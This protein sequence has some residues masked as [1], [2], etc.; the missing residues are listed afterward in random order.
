LI[1]TVSQIKILLPGMF[2]D[3]FCKYWNWAF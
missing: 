3:L 2:W 1:D